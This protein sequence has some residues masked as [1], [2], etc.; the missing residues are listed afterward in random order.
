MVSPSSALMLSTAMTSD[1]VIRGASRCRATVVLPTLPETLMTAIFTG[2]PRKKEWVRD[3]AFD[4]GR[5]DL[6]TSAGIAARLDRF[7]PSRGAHLDG[8]AGLQDHLD[9]PGCRSILWRL[10]SRRTV[11]ALTATPASSSASRMPAME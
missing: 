9:V 8:F 1:P 7:Q 5:G 4:E 2:A 10:I 6:F 11:E 3:A